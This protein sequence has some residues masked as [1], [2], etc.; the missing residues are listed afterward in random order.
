MVS[1]LDYC[2]RLLANLPVK[3]QLSNESLL[4]KQTYLHRIQS[5]WYFSTKKFEGS[6]ISNEH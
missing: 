6:L 3:P 2:N 5:R 4:F 1:S